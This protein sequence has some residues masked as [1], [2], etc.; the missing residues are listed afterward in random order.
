MRGMNFNKTS[1]SGHSWLIHRRRANKNVIVTEE[2]W[3]M[4]DVQ[5]A[6]INV[7]SKQRV[8]VDS[9]LNRC[10]GV[11]VCESHVKINECGVQCIFTSALNLNLYYI[12]I[13]FENAGHGINS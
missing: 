3:Q 2:R 8:S 5:K 1:H 10:P 6:I 9:L 7:R 13:K 12:C 4:L 11:Y